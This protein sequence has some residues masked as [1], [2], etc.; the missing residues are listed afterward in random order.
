MSFDTS[1]PES[2]SRITSICLIAYHMEGQHINTANLRNRNKQSLNDGRPPVP[3]KGMKPLPSTPRAYQ[4]DLK[5]LPLPPKP[6]PAVPVESEKPNYA[7][8]LYW[9]VFFCI[10]FLL[11]V[12]LLPIILEKDAMPGL[13][14][15]LRKWF[16]NLTGESTYKT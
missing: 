4:K 8:T 10:W 2:L 5:R 7:H 15:I 9:T 13:N 16:A 6:L 14:R 3:N 1:I 12:L 11:T